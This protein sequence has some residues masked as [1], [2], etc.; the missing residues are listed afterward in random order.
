MFKPIS[1]FKITANYLTTDS[2]LA[3]HWPSLSE[4]NDDIA[5]FPWLSEEECCLYFPSDTVTTLPVM[6][7]APLW[8]CQVVLF[9]LFPNSTPLFSQS[10]KVMTTFSLFHTASVQMKP[11]NGI[12][13]KLHSSN[14][15]L[16][17]HRVCRM[18]ASFWNSSFATLVAREEVVAKQLLMVNPS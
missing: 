15:C 1:P 3:F 17:T 6:Y 4:L 10:F 8:H 14:Q 11:M 13:Y 9:L 18:D 5:P 16:Y 2:A 7:T 12:W